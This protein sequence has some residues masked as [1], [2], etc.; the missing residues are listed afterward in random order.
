MTAMNALAWTYLAYLVV[1]VGV[2]IWVATTLR[3]H[4]VEFLVHREE[5]RDRT[6]SLVHLLIVGFY[7]INF[8]MISFALKAENVVTDMQTGIEL[9]STKVG[10]VLVILGAMHFLILAV[11]SKARKSGEKREPEM[12]RHGVADL[13]A[14]R[15]HHA[16]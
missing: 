15:Q 10:T 3:K 2:T 1:C 5:D 11:F 12:Q 16:R 4:G 9:I 13:L 8:G 14:Q 6:R 7:L